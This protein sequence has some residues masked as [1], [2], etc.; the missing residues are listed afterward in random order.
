MFL[1]SIDNKI[2]KI[3]ANFDNYLSDKRS[4]QPPV[5]S[6]R[7]PVVNMS[8]SSHPPPNPATI[9]QPPP[10]AS[11]VA[12]KQ[13]ELEIKQMILQGK[14]YEKPPIGIRN[15]PREKTIAIS[16]AEEQIRLKLEIKVVD[17]NLEIKINTE[18]STIEIAFKRASKYKF[19]KPESGQP[20]WM[21][22]NSDVKDD[23]I[24]LFTNKDGK[25]IRSCFDAVPDELIKVD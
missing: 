18:K 1:D 13:V 4:S 25:T 9:A 3:K 8:H 15:V 11:Q 7:R 12:P 22:M 19:V 16:Y 5:P 21:T 2:N 6:E 10:Q 17:N 14:T 24:L 20:M 23:K